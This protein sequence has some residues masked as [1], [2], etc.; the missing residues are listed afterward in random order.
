METLILQLCPSYISKIWKIDKNEGSNESSLIPK[1]KLRWPVNSIKDN[2]T[3]PILLTNKTD[4]QI[5]YSEKIKPFQD[6]WLNLVQVNHDH[7]TPDWKQKMNMN[8]AFYDRT[9]KMVKGNPIFANDDLLIIET[10][11]ILK[12]YEMTIHAIIVKR[13][14]LFEN[15]IRQKE[16]DVDDFLN[17]LYGSF[18]ALVCFWII[19]RTKGYDERIVPVIARVSH[20]L[21]VKLD[22][23][24]ETLDILTSPEERDMMNRAEQWERQNL[25][26]H[27]KAIQH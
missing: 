7:K 17:S 5:V 20:D 2:I 18:M 15:I 14:T 9:L 23:Y 11:E 21:A 19:A 6:G 25:K 13:L 3:N 27:R 1:G 26:Q 10:V 22:S 24:T 16:I 12:D 8:L 4:I